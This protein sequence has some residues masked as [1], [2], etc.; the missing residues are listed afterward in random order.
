MSGYLIPLSA[1]AIGTF[2][3]T[4]VI[5]V[6]MA[7]DNKLSDYGPITIGFTL[8][9]M[10]FAMGHLSGAHYNPAVTIA[11][12]IRNKCDNVTKTLLYILVQIVAAIFGSLVGYY[13]TREFVYPS[14]GADYD[15]GKAFLVEALF[16]FA[17]A[18]VMLNVATTKS[19][20]D[21]SFYGLAIGGTL[22]AAAYC[23][24]RISGSCF[25][26][27]VA[28]GLDFI[29]VSGG[30]NISDIWIYLFAPSIGGVLAGLFFLAQNQREYQP[31]QHKTLEQKTLLNDKKEASY[32][33]EADSGAAAGAYP[34]V[35]PPVDE[36][37]GSTEIGA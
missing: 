14:V 27:A 17:L 12:A 23:C 35:Q 20:E 37:L 16:T 36:E 6:D 3:L 30:G 5:Q 2:F 1:E 4:L 34:T 25:N 18:H 24:K 15:D 26:P 21:N 9:V 10:V 13:I 33:E 32:D 28:I 11:V 22:L 31:V 19:L 29:Y 7:A 8:M